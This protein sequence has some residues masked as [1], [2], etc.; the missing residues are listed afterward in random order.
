M[1]GM[2]LETCWAFNERWNNKFYYKVASCWLFLLRHTTMHGSMNI[3]CAKYS[4]FRGTGT[5]D[6]GPLFGNVCECRFLS[7]TLLP[8]YRGAQWQ[9]PKFCN[10]KFEVR[11]PH[12]ISQIIKLYSRRLKVSTQLYTGCPKRNVPDFRRVF[13]M[14]KYTDI[15]QNTYIQSWTVTEIMAR[16]VWNFDICYTLVDYQIHIKTGRN[17]WFL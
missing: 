9:L 5:Q 1:S 16:E 6:L 13:L 2:P 8:V 14:L 3:K 10:L 15:T 12:C 11:H 4:Q 17:M 7:E